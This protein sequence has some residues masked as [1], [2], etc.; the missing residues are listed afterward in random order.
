MDRGYYHRYFKL[1][2]HNWWFQVRLKIIHQLIKKQVGDI[3]T[4]KVLNLGIA[5]GA[6]SEMLTDFGHVTSSEYD[7][8]TCEF[9]RTQLKMEVVQASITELP[10]ENN[11][12]DLVCAFDVVEH[13]EDDVKAFSEMKRVA[14]SNGLVVTTV[15][16]FMSLWSEHDVINHHYRR[17]DKNQILTLAQNAGLKQVRSTYFNTILFLPIYLVRMV[18]N[19]FMKKKQVSSDFDIHLPFFLNIILK[20]IFSI[21]RVMLKFIN[22]PFGVSFLNISHK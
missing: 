20:A 3:K 19:I 7:A 5:T 11:T 16:A 12:F 14:K 6:S 1:E 17:Y 4:L 21:E 15:P 13:V 8:E 2:R 18:K 22:F 10:F 9:L